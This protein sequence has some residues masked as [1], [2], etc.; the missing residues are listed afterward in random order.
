MQRAGSATPATAGRKRGTRCHLAA[1]NVFACLS[2]PT[3]RSLQRRP[4]R[5]N[6]GGR[7][8][9]GACGR[10]RARARRQRRRARRTPRRAAR[11]GQPRGRAGGVCAGARGGR[12]RR[13]RGRAG[14]AAA[15]AAAG[16]AGTTGRRGRRGGAAPGWRPTLY[17]TPPLSLLRGVSLRTASAAEVCGALQASVRRGCTSAGGR[18]PRPPAAAAALPAPRFAVCS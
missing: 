7:S 13:A 15:R 6:A 2:R 1:A 12:G 14:G 3:F 5:C 17:P 8:R 16:G 4:L 11:C 18:S 9:R 10:A